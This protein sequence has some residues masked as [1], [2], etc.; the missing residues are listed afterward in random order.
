MKHSMLVM[1]GMLAM[2][3]CLPTCKKAA[4]TAPTQTSDYTGTYTL[5]T[6]NGNKIPYT[7]THEAGA[8][9][10]QSGTI[11]LNADGTFTSAM[12]YGLPDGK[13][14]SRDFSGTY[15]RDGS[16]FSLQ[17]KGAGVNT[18]TLEGNTFTMN[19]E[20]VLFAYVK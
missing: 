14:A 17:W 11:T 9:E 12:S 1:M 20:G 19:N 6:I 3:L 7:P 5:V 15:T 2:G 8:P 16:R 4:P 18:A 10:V 13:V